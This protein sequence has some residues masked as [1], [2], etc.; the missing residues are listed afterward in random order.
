MKTLSS[1]PLNPVVLVRDTQSGLLVAAGWSSGSIING[2]GGGQ[3]G[4]IEKERAVKFPIFAF[5]SG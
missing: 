4:G 2:H 3:S 5:T 1:G